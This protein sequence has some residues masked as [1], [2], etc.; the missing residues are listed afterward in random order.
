LS[1]DYVGQWEYKRPDYLMCMQ[2]C[3]FLLYVVVMF[4]SL[5]DFV[6]LQ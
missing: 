3:V 6:Y 5:G 1:I 2:W 4:V